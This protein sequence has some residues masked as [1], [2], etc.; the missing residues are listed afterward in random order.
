MKSLGIRILLEFLQAPGHCADPA[1]SACGPDS[2]VLV[3]PTI[4]ACACCN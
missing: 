4:S 3:D 1:I 2:E